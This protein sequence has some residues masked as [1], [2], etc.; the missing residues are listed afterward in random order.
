MTLYP[1][2]VIHKVAGE[3]ESLTYPLI[4]TVPSSSSSTTAMSRSSLATGSVPRKSLSFC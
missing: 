1:S 4:P 3:V 2:S